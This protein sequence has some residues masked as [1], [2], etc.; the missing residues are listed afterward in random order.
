MGKEITKLAPRGS[1]ATAW[2]RL[3]SK[4]VFSIPI[5]TEFNNEILPVVRVSLSGHGGSYELAK[6]TTPAEITPNTW[7][8]DKSLLYLRP[9]VTLRLDNVYFFVNGTGNWKDETE[10][11][12]SATVADITIEA[13]LSDITYFGLDVPFGYL[14][15]IFS[16]I[17]V[18]GT[19]TR[20]WQYWNGST[21]TALTV[22]PLGTAN[23]NWS[24]GNT[25]EFVFDPPTNWATTSVGGVIQGESIAKIRYWIRSIVQTANYTTAGT[26]SQFL[27]SEVPNQCIT[28]AWCKITLATKAFYGGGFYYK[29]R[30]NISENAANTSITSENTN[31]FHQAAIGTVVAGS[32]GNVDIAN[33]D[34]LLDGALK[35]WQFGGGDMEFLAGFEDMPFNEFISMRIAKVRRPIRRDNYVTLEFA[36][37][38]IK[39]ERDILQ[40]YFSD[41]DYP[42]MDKSKVG[43]PIPIYFGNTEV[44]FTGTD[45]PEIRGQ[46]ALPGTL[47]KQGTASGSGY[48]NQAYKFGT[49]ILNPETG[50]LHSFGTVAGVSILR[51]NKWIDIA[52]L[53]YDIVEGRTTTGGVVIKFKNNYVVDGPIG[54]RTQGIEDDSVGT[55]TGTAYSIISK[56]S[57]VAHFIMICLCGYR[58]YELNLA[59]FTEVGV[60][61]QGITGTLSIPTTYK[62]AVSVYVG[63]QTSAREV[64]HRLMLGIRGTIQPDNSGK[65][66]IGLI[67][68]AT[69]ADT[70]TLLK[71]M[72]SGFTET[73]DDDLMVSKLSVMY[74]QYPSSNARQ[75]AVGSRT[76][77]V[78]TTL[79]IDKP[80][81]AF[82]NLQRD[83][84]FETYMYTAAKAQALADVLYDFFKRGRT[85]YNVTDLYG[86]SMERI[87]GDRI[88]FRMPRG[89]GGELRGKPAYLITTNRNYGNCT[90]QLEAIEA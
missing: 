32:A 81:D 59:T 36:N 50:N 55:F 22:T 13:N 48:I 80:A 15:L 57:D 25:Q 73:I 71:H 62:D 88:I 58:T 72:T 84:E 77:I 74:R 44:L 31:P 6:E 47:I 68:S 3:A 75:R 1:D 79:C 64:L 28:T 38:S 69:D 90:A 11:A 86:L 39:M 16:T 82:F 42:T 53:N 85:V 35:D 60:T 4:H 19:G 45:T 63:E 18:P 61:K 29:P 43:K 41:A 40:S 26:G 54:L 20:A 14:K 89:I 67:S 52:A 70:A 17:P 2:T 33:G 65:M 49:R 5:E 12:A 34:G 56:P 27:T 7:S 46:R 8:Y 78:G 66:S 10:D 9:A 23:N 83:V 51:G 24:S 30:L 87:L 76:Q 21:W 37:Q